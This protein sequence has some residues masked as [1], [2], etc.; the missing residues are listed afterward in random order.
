MARA[1]LE[2]SRNDKGTP[3]RFTTASFFWPVSETELGDQAEEEDKEVVG[4]RGVDQDEEEEAD[5]VCDV[6][7]NARKKAFNWSGQSQDSARLTWAGFA[8]VW[9]SL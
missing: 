7:A 2:G 3:R 6:E 4:L 8:F 5:G 1:K 9:E